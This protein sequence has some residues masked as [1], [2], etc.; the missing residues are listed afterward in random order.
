MRN[1]RKAAE[2]DVQLMANRLARLKSE[3][4][5]ALRKVGTC[6]LWIIVF[7]HLSSCAVNASTSM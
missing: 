7:T 5:Q 4:Q 6:C 3:E 1:E 2:M